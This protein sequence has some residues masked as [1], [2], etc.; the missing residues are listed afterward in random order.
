MFTKEQRSNH[1]HHNPSGHIGS[2]VIGAVETVGGTGGDIGSNVAG[3]GMIEIAGGGG[4]GI[5][6]IGKAALS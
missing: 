3:G 1:N 4:G 5:G 6:G 2:G